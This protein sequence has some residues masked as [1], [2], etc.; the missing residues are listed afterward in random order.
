MAQVSGTTQ[1][2]DSAGLREDLEDV[3][4]DLFPNDT[5]ALS[6]LDKVD[7]TA[8]FHEWQLDS[9]DAATVN[10]QTE[11]NDAAYLT[12]AAPTRIGN[13]CQISSKWFLISGTL[14]AVKKAGRKSEVARQAMKKMRELKRDMEKVLVGNQGSSAGSDAVPRSCAG[15]EACIASTDNSGNG[16]K[17]TTTAGGCTAAFAANVFTTPTD[18]GSTTGAL[19]LTIFNQALQEAWTDGGDP[20]IVL[21]GVTQKTAID[22]FTSIATRMVD[23]ERK[24]QAVI[25]N[26]ANVYVSDYGIHTV[27]LHR[28]MRTSVVLCLDPDYWAT[29]FLRRP[30]MEELAKTGD[31]EKRQII[32][33]FT[34]V[35][36]NPNSSAKVASCS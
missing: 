32:T 36:R 28:Y 11:G 33:E 12:V 34:L 9:L 2:F 15:M 23:I 13:Y 27:L 19:S 30:K 17:A 5:W 18:S 4:W 6:N 31:G 8:V 7:A 26:A 20:R 14:E 25:H 24:Q 10:R 1:T 22:G 16:L 29:A 21:A 35:A 3:I